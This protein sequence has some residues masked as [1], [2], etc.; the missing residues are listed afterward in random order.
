MELVSKVLTHSVT[1]PHRLP[2]AMKTG[3]KDPYSN[4]L[5]REQII[6]VVLED[7]TVICYDAELN[8][9]WEK[10]VGHFSMSIEKMKKWFRID[11]INVHISPINIVH[12]EEGKDISD[13]GLVVVG[14]S[15][16]Y[17][18]HDTNHTE[19]F[20]LERIRME[21]GFDMNEDGEEEHPDMSLRNQLEHFSMYAL[22]AHSGRVVWKHDGTE[23]RNEQYTKSMP[24]HSIDRLSYAS[25]K[26]LALQAHHTV[27]SNDW[28]VFKDSLINELPH[29]WHSRDDTSIRMAHFVRQHIGSR[30]HAKSSSRKHNNPKVKDALKHSI[31][32]SKARL[33]ALAAA[34]NAGSNLNKLLS[35]RE[36]IAGK[37][38]KREFITKHVNSLYNRDEE[39][40]SDPG[41]PTREAMRRAEERAA[42]RAE[43]EEL[44]EF[45]LAH[46]R[47]EG[48][49]MPEVCARFDMHT[50]LFFL[51][52]NS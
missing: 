37:Q 27:N 41:A 9:L 32:N 17:I 10:E 49:R 24:Q 16:T 3:Y 13:N 38:S 46:A 33:S 29:D 39:P 19:T 15:M 34:S 14:A 4:E 50:M 31:D 51:F 12:E 6:V 42:K 52:A 25:R 36:D 47:G 40:N 23:L 5:V 8:I 11:S 45:R 44:S 20:D 18:E 35:K 26:D 2:V 43:L 28:T 30:V 7:W 22:S 1:E 21:R 48:I